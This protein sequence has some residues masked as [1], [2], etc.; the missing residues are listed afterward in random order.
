[1]IVD[2]DFLSHWKT[3]MLIDELGGDKAAPLYLIALWAHCQ[4]RRADTF[5]NMAPTG[6]KAVCRY[7]GEASRLRS[8]LERCGWIELRGEAVVVRGFAELNAKLVANWENGKKGGRKKTH[9]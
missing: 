2:P 4:Q 9:Q 8:A 3:Q 5:H 7:E 6:L 1:V